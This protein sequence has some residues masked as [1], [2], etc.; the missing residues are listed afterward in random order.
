MNPLWLWLLAL[1]PVTL[2]IATVL[3]RVYVCGFDRWIFGYLL[4][5]SRRRP[6]TSSESIH[7]FLCIADHFEP[8]HGG[9]DSNVALARVNRWVEEFPTQFR[10][11]RDSD[12]KTPQHSFFYPAEEYE[13]ELLESLQRLCRDG[14]GEIEIH[15]HHHDDTSENLSRQLNTFKDTLS[16]RHGSLARHQDTGAFGYAFIHGNWALDNSRPDGRWCGVN[17]ELS[18]L[19][20]TGCYVDMTF[21]S[22][23]SPTQPPTIN[24]IYRAIDDPDKPRSHDFGIPVRAGVKPSPGLLLIQGPLVLD[25]TRRKFGVLPRIE[26]ACLQASQPPS[27][28]RLD[29]WL[30]ASIRVDG[31]PDWYF[32]KL[33]THGALEQNADVLLG[34][35][36]VDLHEELSRRTAK[37]PSFQYHYVTAREMV[38]IVLAAESGVAEWR[39]DWRDFKWA[40]PELVP[41]RPR[42][43]HP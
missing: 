2:L 23:P 36:M 29:N 33:H 1:L 42:A 27:G 24:S 40:A 34:P 9:V 3:R 28:K 31:R 38:N 19:E 30:R 25:W 6:P 41:T 11:F 37:Q 4:S 18:I 16:K 43:S 7:V 15:L 26:N 22:A 13:P 14:F 35:P 5:R 8:K 21:P 17:D 39:M 20:R 12:G 10:R 32:V